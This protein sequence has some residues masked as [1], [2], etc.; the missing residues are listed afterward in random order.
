MVSKRCN[1]SK[2]LRQLNK[3]YSLK[4][5]SLAF[6]PHRLGA[7][8]VWVWASPWGLAYPLGATEPMEYSIKNINQQGLAKKR[9]IP[10]V[11][12]VPHIDPIKITHSA[13]HIPSGILPS[14]S[15][16]RPKTKVQPRSGGYILPATSVL[17]TSVQ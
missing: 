6:L 2:L 10:I 11:E 16:Q 1:K 7:Y 14:T 9:N 12:R 3:H 4:K 5:Q 8:G 13:T 15:D 17:S